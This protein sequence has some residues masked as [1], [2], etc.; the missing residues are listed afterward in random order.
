MTRS[1]PSV[2]DTGG[3]FVL[4]IERSMAGL[5]R[6]SGWV[7]H[8][9]AALQLGAAAEYA[10]RLCLEEAAANVVM[11]GGMDGAGTDAGAGN[12]R[13]D[14]G[15]GLHGATGVGASDF[16]ALLVTPAAEALMVTVEDH[17]TAFDP[18]TVP[19]PVAPKSLEEAQIG[20]LGIHLMRQYARSVC[21]ER[22]GSVNRLTLTVPRAG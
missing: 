8:I 22:V 5:G 1:P 7:D 20:G 9:A 19:P 12:P 2:A 4:R 13:D 18:L 10:L 14:D 3:G 21:Y 11:H 15:A 16:V 6:L 17:C